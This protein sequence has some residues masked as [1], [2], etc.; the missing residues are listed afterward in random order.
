MVLLSSTTSTLSPFRLRDA[1]VDTGYP[2]PICGPCRAF[3][4][5]MV[6]SDDGFHNISPEQKDLYHIGHI[7][8]TTGSAARARKPVCA[9][10]GSH[11]QS[12]I[13]HANWLWK[14]PMRA[15]AQAITRHVA[16]WRNQPALYSCAR[17]LQGAAQP[18]RQ[19]FSTLTGHS[20]HARQEDSTGNS[21]GPN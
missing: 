6:P 14:H 20:S 7:A 3:V 4:A 21:H 10:A 5:F 16:V 15:A 17:R 18:G 9:P 19:S 8:A 11:L 2:R 1:F 12:G 13:Q